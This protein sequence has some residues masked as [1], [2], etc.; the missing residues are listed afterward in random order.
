MRATASNDPT[1]SSDAVGLVVALLVR[2]AEIATIASHPRA[3]TIVLTFVVRRRIDRTEAGA[4]EE[5]VAE[6]VRSLLDVEGEEA[7]A[8]AVSCESDDGVTFVRVACQ[9]RTFNRSTLAMLR[10]L[11]ADRYGDALLTSPVQ[12]DASDEDQAS[13]DELIDGAIEALRDSSRQK[14]LVGVREEKRVLVYFLK[15]R[16]SMKAAAR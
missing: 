2:C 6:H 16:K 1:E 14:S 4:L 11:F 9:A 7:L 13:A 5:S 12:D 8:P 10:A 15:A 3:G